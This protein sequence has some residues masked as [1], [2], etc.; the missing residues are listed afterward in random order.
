MQ[1]PLQSRY[2]WPGNIL[3]SFFYSSGWPQF[4]LLQS[5]V[6]FLQQVPFQRRQRAFLI[7][8]F[9]SCGFYLSGSPGLSWRTLRCMRVKTFLKTRLAGRRGET[10]WFREQCTRGGEADLFIPPGSVS[11]SQGLQCR[12]PGQCKQGMVASPGQ[13]S[14]FSL[15]LFCSVF[16]LEGVDLTLGNGFSSF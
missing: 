5:W 12:L 1:V 14:A 8:H 10:A 13:S 11:L 7:R 3:I 9:L 15:F 2:K 16:I 4:S 6:Q